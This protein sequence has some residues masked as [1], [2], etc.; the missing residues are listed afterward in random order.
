MTAALP[1]HPIGFFL[2]LAFGA[3]AFV[4]LCIAAW[5]S[6]SD[7]PDMAEGVESEK[8]GPSLV[9]SAQG[10]GTDRIFDWAQEVPELKET[11]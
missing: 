9:N 6:F 2:V 11:A 5:P 7:S 8:S 10:P 1:P 4:L 3:G